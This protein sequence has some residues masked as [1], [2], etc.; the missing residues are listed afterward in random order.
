EQ[1]TKVRLKLIEKEF[2]LDGLWITVAPSLISHNANN[3]N[4]NN[5]N[6]PPSPLSFLPSLLEFSDWALQTTS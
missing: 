1:L 4:N 6:C 3:N 5:N 2:S